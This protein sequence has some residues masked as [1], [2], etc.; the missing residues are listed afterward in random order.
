[1][2]I[3]LSNIEVHALQ[4]ALGDA[5]SWRTLEYSRAVKADFEGQLARIRNEID[6]E[7]HKLV[8]AVVDRG[9]K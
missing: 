4:R 1:M 3:T 9:F 2:T 8:M 5:E 6:I 7:S